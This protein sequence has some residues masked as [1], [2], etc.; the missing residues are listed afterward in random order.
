M[1]PDHPTTDDSLYVFISYARPNQGV[2]EQ[3]ETFLKMAGVCVFRDA[4]IASA[5]NWDMAIE[6]ALRDCDRMVLLLSASSMPYRK[7][8]YREWF[9]FDQEKKP[10]HPLYIEKCT[11]HSRMYAYNYIDA[12]ADLNAALR[13]LLADLRKPFSAPG[14]MMGVDRVMV[15][16]AAERRTVPEAFAALQAAICEPKGSVALAPEQI[17][18]LIEHK[19]ADATE[20]RLARVA[21]WS[22]PRYALDN[23]FVNLTLLVDQGEDAQGQRWINPHEN[24]RFND[25]RDVLKEKV[26]D[27]ALV[28]LGAPGSG[29]STLLRRLQ[30][31]DAAD[32]LCGRAGDD[33]LSF[34]VALNSYRDTSKPRQWLADEWKRRYPD[35]EP[36]DELI[37]TGRMLFL[38]DALNEM[39]H[40]NVGEYHERVELWRDFIQEVTR[41]GCRAIFSCRS[42]DYS[43]PLSS[44][45]LRVPQIVVQ[46]MDAEQVRQFLDVYLP[47]QAEAI[48]EELDGSPQFDLFRTPYFLKLLVD[49][50]DGGIPKGRASLFTGFVRQTLTREISGGNRLFEPNGLLTERDH[51]RIAQG[52]WRDPFDLPER[53][54]LIPKL[55]ELAYQMQA[56]R[57]ATAGGQIRVDFDTACELLKHERDEDI[58]RAG[59]ALNVLDEDTAREEVLF[60]HQLLQ[61]F[62]AARKLAD[63][64]DMTKIRVEWRADAVKPSLEET[65]AGLADSDPLP[66]LPGTGWE[67]T[68]ILA[69]V[70]NENPDA[71]LRDLMAVNLPL[72]GRAAVGAEVKISAELKSDLQQALIARAQDKN[73][74]LRARIAAGE[75]LGTLGDPRFERKTG[76][77]GDYLLPPLVSIEGGVYPV[78]D[79]ASDYAFEK[80]AHTVELAPFQI[81]VFPVTNAEYAL[82]IAA[83]GYEDEQWWDTEAA[84]AWL[85]GEGSGEGAKQAWR[86]NKKTLESVSEDDIRR[87]VSENRITSKQA[88]D[89]ITIRNWTTERFEQQLE[90]WYPSGKVYRQPE[91]WDDARFNSP[92]QPVVG[93]T[94]FEARAY[95]AWLSAQ[96]GQPFRLPTEVEFEAAARGKGGRKFPYGDTFDSGRCNTFESHLRRSTPVGIFDNATPEGAFDLSGNV[97]TWITTVYDQAQFPYPYQAEDGREDLGSTNVRR[98]LRGGSWHDG[99]YS[100]RAVGRNYD[101]PHERDQNGGFRLACSSPIF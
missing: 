55:S 71:Y 29:K 82:F 77:Y 34:F 3:V 98:V 63:E 96:T 72:A 35:L 74:D 37:N 39:P 45:D 88:D 84:K 30:W 79:D 95:C 21:E 56:N 24:R 32:H 4:N 31:D 59:V 23:R 11:L 1:T 38:L 97:Y 75:A 80:P 83:G 44:K 100:A 50:A 90:E 94:W 92:A 17:K 15:T 51:G 16:D 85:R 43:A 57:S 9:Y 86:D 40:R 2:A 6:N 54:A 67:E 64:P 58:L 49:Q 81:G 25:L 14:A 62:F 10:I 13:R 70:L 33:K 48:W 78:G 66:P 52:K 46:P 22:Q 65:L 5:D 91:Y 99:Q 73:A 89:W 8:V 87:M 27:P 53:G 26:D 101:L 60:F 68:A 19:P 69:A 76:A 41:T 93:V 42:L 12:R 28:L 7:E 36:L 18:Q 47:A 61:E 20:Y